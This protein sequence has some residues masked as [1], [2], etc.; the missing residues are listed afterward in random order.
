MAQVLDVGGLIQKLAMVEEEG[1]AF[2][3]S[4][5]RRT[6]NEKIRKLAQMMMRAERMHRLAFLKL[7]AKLEARRAAA[8]PADKLTADF[9]RYILALIDHR[10]FLSPEQAATAAQ[11]LADENEAIDMAIGFERD[12]ILLLR[13]CREIAG[14]EGRKLI[15]KFI[16]QEKTHIVALQKARAILSESA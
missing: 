14:V 1:A 3:E 15:D 16:E 4:L 12:N 10:I 2:Y 8:K 7:S 5:A 11:N 6:G 9:R 13:E